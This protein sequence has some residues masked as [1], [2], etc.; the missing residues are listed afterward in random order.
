MDLN[1]RFALYLPSLLGGGA[2][3]VTLNLAEG[4]AKAGASVDLVLA[5]ATGPLLNSVPPCVRVVDLG[6]RRVMAS[7]PALTRYL[8]QERPTGFLS[9]LDHAN[10]VA[11]WANRLAGNPTRMVVAIHNTPSQDSGHALSLR[12]RLI[13]LSMRLFYPWADRIVA[14]SRGVAED[15][16]AL[17]GIRDRLEVVYNPVI[18]PDFGL[19]AEAPP[20][21]PWLAP[22]QPPVVL[23]VGRLT[24]QK[25]FPN[26]IRAFAEVRKTQTLRLMILGEGEERAALEALVH[27]LGL[28][29]DVELPGFVPDP[30]AYIKRA[31]LFVLSSDWEGLPTVLIEALALSTPIVATDCKSGPREILDGGRWGRLVP[32]GDASALAAAIA[33]ALTEPRREVPPEV[34]SSYTQGVVVE[35]YLRLLRGKVPQV[36][37][38]GKHPV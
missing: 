17:T 15:F 28:S 32:V 8:R 21:H 11:L 2:E 10:V 3:R 25:N 20:N 1:E 29:A 18:S 9:A 35:T 27:E 5:Q 16:T 4:M 22:G 12:G 36:L 19:K 38:E 30:L 13:P 7:L 24:R 33:A 37:I 23:G 31:A 6:A 14:V 34:Y 26:L